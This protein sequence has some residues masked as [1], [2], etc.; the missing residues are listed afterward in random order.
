MVAAI[1]FFRMFG[2]P[3]AWFVELCAGFAL[4]TQPCL[5]DGVPTTQSASLQWAGAATAMLMVIAVLVALIAAFMAW[6]AFKRVRSGIR[7]DE[8]ESMD[9]GVGRARFLALWGILLGCVFALATAMTAVGF[10]MLPR[11]AQA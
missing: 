5:V 6:H 7:G 9:A 3:A 10:L 11:C 8:P 1:G 2:G 4:A